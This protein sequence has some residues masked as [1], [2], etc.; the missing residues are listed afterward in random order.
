[1]MENK[2]LKL[3]IGIQTF[4]RIRKEGYLYVD[5]T[6]Y[7]VDL[8]DSGSIYFLARP[9]RFGK[10]VM[11]ST[12]DALFSGEK[13][14][15]KGLY[16]EEFVNRSDFKPS[17]VIRM[18]MSKVTTNRG[19]VEIENDIIKIVKDIAICRGV[20]LSESNLPGSLLD[21]LIPNSAKVR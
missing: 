12:F 6:K 19:I 1:M 3:P 18:D 4:E 20:T 21:D 2:R 13:E 10:S 9:R 15:F 7:L 16:A 17:P 8:I 11:I 5:K 14:L